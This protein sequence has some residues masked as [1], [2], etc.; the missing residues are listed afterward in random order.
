MKFIADFHIHS[1]YSRAT[2]SLMDLENLDR[3]A[4]IKGVKVLSK[5]GT[6]ATLEID[7]DKTE[8]SSA[9]RKILSITDAHDI[10]IQDLSI[11]E[12]IKKIYREGFK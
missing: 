11:E 4:K 1:K 2:S 6:N 12:I 9:I 7:C 3:W 5:L 10:E 8:L